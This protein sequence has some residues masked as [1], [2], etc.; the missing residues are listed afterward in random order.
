MIKDDDVLVHNQYGELVG[1]VR[2]VGAGMY[3]PYGLY[4]DMSEEKLPMVT[5]L[6]EAKRAIDKWQKE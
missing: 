3:I 4:N 5:S 6:H 2:T 1:Y